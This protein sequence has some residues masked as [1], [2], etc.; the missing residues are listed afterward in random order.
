MINPNSPAMIAA[1]KRFERIVKARQEAM[2]KATASECQT[3]VV[4][5]K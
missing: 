5:S 3:P 1:S 2:D 4:E